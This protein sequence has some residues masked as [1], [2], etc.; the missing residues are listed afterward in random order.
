ME[1]IETIDARSVDMSP[2]SRSIATRRPAGPRRRR[3]RR[4][5]GSED[6]WLC[7]LDSGQACLSWI[8][9]QGGLPQNLCQFGHVRKK[10]WILP[11]R[12]NHLK[13]LAHD[14]QYARVPRQ[15]CPSSF[16]QRRRR[17]PEGPRAAPTGLISRYARRIEPVIPACGDLGMLNT[18]PQGRHVIRTFLY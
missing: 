3:E 17:W 10:T 5:V 14:V 13:R 8:S 18:S 2:I 4:L 15:N 16:G 6:P 1:N 11:K 9:H 12:H 7:A